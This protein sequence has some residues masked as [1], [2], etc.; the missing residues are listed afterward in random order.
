MQYNQPNFHFFLT[1][2][3]L[4][5]SLQ[6]ALYPAQKQVFAFS[7]AAAGSSKLYE[8]E[9]RKIKL[10]VFFFVLRLF[11]CCMVPFYLC[12]VNCTVCFE[13]NLRVQ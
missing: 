8:K 7:T 13:T 11:V 3:G 2:E 5:K 6:S 4:D 12:I 10:H 1:M 9:R